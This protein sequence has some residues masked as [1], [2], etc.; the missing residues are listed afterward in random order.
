MGSTYCSVEQ[1]VF[2][3]FKE[4]QFQSECYY[5]SL[6]CLNVMKAECRVRHYP[7]VAHCEL[8]GSQSIQLQQVLLD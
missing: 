8:H 7:E 3:H 2:D 6:F 5:T 4:L 1:N